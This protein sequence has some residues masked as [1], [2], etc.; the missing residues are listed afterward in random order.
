MDRLTQFRH[1]AF[2]KLHFKVFHSVIKDI[3]AVISHDEYVYERISRREN[4][5]INPGTIFLD[6]VR[7]NNFTKLTVKKYS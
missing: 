4:S 6:Y 5:W 7:E 3:K 2:L 1:V